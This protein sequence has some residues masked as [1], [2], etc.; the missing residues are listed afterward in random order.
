VNVR[1]DCNRGNG[2][3]KSAGSNQ[4]RFG[5][6]ILTRAMCPPGSLHNRIVKDWTVI[7]SYTIKDG[8]LFLSLI[9]D[10]GIYEFKPSGGSSPRASEEGHVTGTVTY[11][12]R[13]ALTRGA[14]VEVKLLE[15]S[16]ADTTSVTVAEQTIKPA[17]HQV[18]IAF[19]LRY[20]PGRID[21]QGRYSI[22]VRILE[23]AELRFSSSDAYP[24]ITG[25]HSNKVDVIVKPVGK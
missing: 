20:D 11:R 10:G 13:V 9:A 24:A 17:G 18:P 8:H 21:P 19:D 3:W 25:G 14:V 1:I 5:P 22:Q 2:A 12:Q 4:V 7:R 15:V 16:R 23:G 6:L